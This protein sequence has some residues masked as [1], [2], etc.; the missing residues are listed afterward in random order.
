[1]YSRRLISTLSPEAKLYRFLTLF[2]AGV[3]LAL[4]F[5]ITS[6][7]DYFRQPFLKW[8]YAITVPL[9]A[10]I[11][12]Y[13]P[14]S[15]PFKRNVIVLWFAFKRDKELYRMV[16]KGELNYLQSDDLHA[17]AAEDFLDTADLDMP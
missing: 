1:M 14:K 13:R 8:T 12:I 16:T 3:I 11:A 15:N 2:D 10:L 9:V 17:V 5:L 6:T 4:W 7:M